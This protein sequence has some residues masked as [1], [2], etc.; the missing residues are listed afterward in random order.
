MIEQ[1]VVTVFIIVFSVT[2]QSYNNFSVDNSIAQRWATISAQST[3]VTMALNPLLEIFQE[4]KLNLKDSKSLII[5]KQIF[6]IDISAQDEMVQ[7]S[8]ESMRSLIL[9]SLYQ[10]TLKDYIYLTEK[11]LNE[12][13][14]IKNYWKFEDFHMQQSFFRKNIVYNFYKSEYS[15]IIKTKLTML[16]ALEDHINTVLGFCLYGLYKIEKIDNEAIIIEQLTD[17]ADQ[18]LKTLHATDYN[19]QNQKDFLVLYDQLLCINNNFYEQV[20]T[21]K[22]RMIENDKNSF[23]S[24]HWVSVTSAIVAAITFIVICKKNETYIKSLLDQ[25]KIAVP[26]FF[27]QYI[28]DPAIG[29]K[30][31][32]W[33]GKVKRL[34]H[35]EPFPDIPELLDIPSATEVPRYEGY[36]TLFVNPVLNPIVETINQT[37]KELLTTVNGW[38]NDFIDMGRNWVKASEKTLNTKIDEVND[39]FLKSNQANIYLATI[40]P[41][42]LGV[43][44]FGSSVHNVYDYQIRYKKWHLPMKQILRSIDQ[45]INK[46]EKP[47]ER[48]SFVDDGKIYVL[49]QQLKGYVDCL[50]NQELFL[51]Y[52]DIK[53]LL[54]FDLNYAQKKGVIDRMYKT[55][56]FL[57]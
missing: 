34:E 3:N 31:V 4:K 36:S 5:I 44:W 13:I 46:I 28:V 20:E 38:K 1:R 16:S 10:K 19:F 57:K 15:K 45:V 56:D 21:F 55:Y 23:I 53:E 39:T 47:L 52:D 40:A 41:V 6:A 11:I 43:Y 30:E 18:F 17:I 26:K 48:H 37:K 42:L 49:A 29:L 12:L 9:L 35:V 33:D 27:Q 32:A 50:N 14:A 2:F 24:D 8:F 51:M 25:G 7:K 54:S 22:V